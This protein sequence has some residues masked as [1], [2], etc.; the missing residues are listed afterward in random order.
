MKHPAFARP[1]ASPCASDQSLA[2]IGDIV[3][4][5]GP[6]F[7]TTSLETKTARGVIGS[8]I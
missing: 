6:P 4:C 7:L 1:R 8:G 3:A 5:T 2:Q